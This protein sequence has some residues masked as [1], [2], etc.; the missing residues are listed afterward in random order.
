MNTG[1]NAASNEIGMK[2][3]NEWSVTCWNLEDKL[4][5]NSSKVSE[6]NNWK[7]MKKR[8]HFYCDTELDKGNKY[9]N[10]SC[11]VQKFLYQKGLHNTDSSLNSTADTFWF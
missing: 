5:Q 3:M 1:V 11:Y 2:L 6:G 8:L 4:L 10:W 7:I 9:T